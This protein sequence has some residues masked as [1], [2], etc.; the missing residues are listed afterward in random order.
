MRHR[1]DNAEKGGWDPNG[2]IR[3]V[4]D[5]LKNILSERKAVEIYKVKRSTLKR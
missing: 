2:M 3:A 4:E 1:K 5:V